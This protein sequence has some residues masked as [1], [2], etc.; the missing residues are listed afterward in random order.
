MVGVMAIS[1]HPAT[2]TAGVVGMWWAAGV[3]LPRATERDRER[4]EAPAVRLC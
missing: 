4:A 1:S 2:P 3:M